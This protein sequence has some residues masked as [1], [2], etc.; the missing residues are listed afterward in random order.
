MPNKVRMLRDYPGRIITL[1]QGSEPE[2]TKE[3]MDK[4]ISEGY[5]ERINKTY[6]DAAT[7]DNLSSPPIQAADEEE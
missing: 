2:L 3:L 6:P 7:F 4:L 5:S 1:K